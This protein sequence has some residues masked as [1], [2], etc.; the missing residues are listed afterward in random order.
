MQIQKH[1]HWMF[2]LAKKIVSVYE[3]FPYG[4]YVSQCDFS[5]CAEDG[6]LWP[7]LPDL[8]RRMKAVVPDARMIDHASVFCLD[9]CGG[10]ICMFPESSPSF[11]YRY[12]LTL[13]CDP[14]AVLILHSD[15]PF[16]FVFQ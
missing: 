9:D 2:P 10:R 12:V 3:S 1:I 13:E 7:N 6:R 15:R 4:V 16:D 11:K 14:Y 8:R 5:F